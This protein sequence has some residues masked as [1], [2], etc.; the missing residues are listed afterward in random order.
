MT[1]LRRSYALWRFLE[2][3]RGGKARK[4]NDYDTASGLRSLN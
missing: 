3:L 2:G 1:N 4:L